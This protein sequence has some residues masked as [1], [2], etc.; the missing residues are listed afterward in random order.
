MAKMV[1]I[2][3]QVQ[4]LSPPTINKERKMKNPFMIA[5]F[6][7]WA[8]ILGIVFAGVHHCYGYEISIGY[9]QDVPVASW[10]SDGL[11][12]SVV[13]LEISEEIRYPW[14][15]A[16]VVSKLSGKLNS[17]QVIDDRYFSGKVTGTAIFS[18]VGVEKKLAGW[19][20]VHGFGG[21]GTLLGHLPEIGDSHIV[22]HFGGRVEIVWEK[23][24]LGY[25]WSH[26]SDPLQHGDKGWNIQFLTIGRRF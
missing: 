18:R 4:F 14:Y 10:Q 1:D 23:W 11:E 25:E 7:V 17:P 6:V 20:S 16:L 2:I 19:L 12:C 13:Q 8:L 3:M 15:G 5:T 21:F 22:G 24:N 9:G 26:M